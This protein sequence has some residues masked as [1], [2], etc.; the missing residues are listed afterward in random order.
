MGEALGHDIPPNWYFEDS[1]P[2]LKTLLPWLK[3]HSIKNLAM[4]VLEKNPTDL[5][6][7]NSDVAILWTIIKKKKGGEERKKKKKKKKKKREKIN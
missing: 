4:G 6:Q 2:L 3:S 5:H 7:A 1:L